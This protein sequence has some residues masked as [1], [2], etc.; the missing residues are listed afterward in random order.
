VAIGRDQLR[1]RY[2]TNTHLAELPAPPQIGSMRAVVEE[3]LARDLIVLDGMDADF[4]A[5]D[6]LTGGFGRDIQGKED[7]E[8]VRVRAIEKRLCHRSPLKVLSETQSSDFLITGSWP[9]VSLP[10]PSTETRKISAYVTV[11]LRKHMMSSSSGPD[12][13]D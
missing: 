2:P 10:S 3:L 9:A 8:L 6:A 13:R 1:C 12:R 7:D 5:G 11:S 4:F